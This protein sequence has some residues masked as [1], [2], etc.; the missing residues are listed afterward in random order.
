MGDFYYKYRNL[1]YEE[2]DKV[3]DSFYRRR[4]GKR[5]FLERADTF[6]DHDRRAL[7]A[8]PMPP[9]KSSLLKFPNTTN[10]FTSQ[11]KIEKYNLFKRSKS[12]NLKS[13]PSK[14]MLE[15]LPKSIESSPS[16]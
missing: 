16:L 7:K 4:K 8:S 15:P 10:I 2:E 11:P 1:F 13:T 5:G 9:I 6:D 3:Y 14:I 12:T